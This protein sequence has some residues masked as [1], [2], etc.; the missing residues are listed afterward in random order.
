M[1]WEA[2]ALSIGICVALPLFLRT[3]AIFGLGYCLSEM[4]RLRYEDA[5][6][7]R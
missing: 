2:L 5:R 4:L 1:P 6:G 7:A 3:L